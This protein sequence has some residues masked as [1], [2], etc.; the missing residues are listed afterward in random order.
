[1][2]RRLQAQGRVYP[3]DVVG[4]E[5]YDGNF[6]LFEPDA[7]LTAEGMQASIRKI[8]GRF[9]RARHMLSIGLNILSF[10]AIVFQLH[11]IGAGWQRWYRRWAR[12][13]HRTGGWLIFRRWT[14]AFRKDGFSGK[15]AEAKRRLQPR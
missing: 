13:L 5:Y 10:P 15:L 9:Y 4:L 6:P 7:P 1:M 2:T 11:R 12:T 14:A 8:M 3:T